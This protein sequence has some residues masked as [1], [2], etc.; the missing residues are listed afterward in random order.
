MAVFDPFGIYVFVRLST[1]RCHIVG[2]FYWKCLSLLYCGR[3]SFPTSTGRQRQLLP[4]CIIYL[5]R[6]RMGPI[7]TS[8]TSI[9]TLTHSLPIHCPIHCP[10]HSHTLSSI[11]FH[12]HFTFIPHSLTRSFLSGNAK[13][14]RNIIIFLDNRVLRGT[15]RVDRA[16]AR[17]RL[18]PR[19]ESTPRRPGRVLRRAARRGATPPT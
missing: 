8:T 11:R 1:L 6:Y 2:R 10:I 16:A 13:N 9:P 17:E 4:T 14:S 19:P 18:G 3:W 5:G 15:W 7:H 12:I